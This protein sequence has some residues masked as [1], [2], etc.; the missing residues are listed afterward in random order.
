VRRCLRI[1]AQA[2]D[3]AKEKTAVETK[4]GLARLV[5]PRVDAR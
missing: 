4:A 1:A 3:N 2:T 5:D